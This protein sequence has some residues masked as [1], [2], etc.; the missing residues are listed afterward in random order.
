MKISLNTP[1]LFL[2]VFFLHT[3]SV[4]AAQFPWQEP[5][6]KLLPNGDIQWQPRPYQLESG[7]EVRYIDYQNGDDSNSGTSKNDPWKH[8][9]WD[10][11]ATGNA[12][13]T[14]GVITYVF[15]GGSIYRGQLNAEESGT[16]EEPIRLTYDPS[17]GEGRP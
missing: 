6:A 12:A 13:G 10:H 17:W 3:A 2:L 5:Q 15:R 8:H 11:D 4:V 9:P 14:L 1:L 16:P 7:G